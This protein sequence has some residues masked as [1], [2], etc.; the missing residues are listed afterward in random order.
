M[1]GPVRGG[2]VILEGDKSSEFGE[3]VV[4]E[5]GWWDITFIN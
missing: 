4:E 3:Q 1:L 5:V 2:A